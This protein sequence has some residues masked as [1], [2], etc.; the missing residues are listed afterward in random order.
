MDNVDNIE[1]SNNIIKNSGFLDNANSTLSVKHD[2]NKTEN[3]YEWLAM[4]EETLPYLDN[5]LRNPKK[6]IINE[7]EIVKVE[8][9]KKVTVESVIHLTQHTN[10]IQDY[11]QENGDVRP[12]KIL[13]INKEE[14]LDTYENRFIYT[15]INNLRTFFEQRVASTG[16]NSFYMDKKD[17]KYQA[18]AKVGTE[19]INIS[20]E[21]NSFDKNIQEYDDTNSNNPLT[22]S[23][24]FKKVKIQLD[25]FSTSELMQT[26]AKLH[27]PPVRSPIRKTNVILKNPNFQ[28]A[29]Q[30]WNYIQSFVPKD[31]VEKDKKEYFDSGVLKK[32]YDGAFLMMYLANN[33]L[34]N[35][36]GGYNET[37]VINEMISR[38]IDNI[39]DT[40]NTLTED[41]LKEIFNKQIASIKKSNHEKTKTIFS[42]LRDRMER[43]KD[44]INDALEL[45]GKDS[46][47]EEVTR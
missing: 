15:L 3:N 28:K 42:I 41:K 12:S 32:E 14:S 30:L 27:V 13:N 35:Y 2:Y 38:L 5:I 20:L 1:L 17:L 9:S 7:E 19:N 6:F 40:D 47:Y 45:L 36:S 21:I 46:N 18:N 37:K 10:L 23:D 34:I 31:K 16:S 24:R 8:L 44:K 33:T 29:E 39:L 4:I 26:L 11:N 22:I 25:G 43:E